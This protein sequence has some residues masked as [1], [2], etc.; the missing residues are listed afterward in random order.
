MGRLNPFLEV[1]QNRPVPPDRRAPARAIL[2]EFCTAVETF[3][4]GGL[5][6]AVTE[7]YQTNMGL[8]HRLVVRSTRTQREHVLL[9]AYIPESG[10]P[11]RLMFYLG[12]PVVTRGEQQ[13]TEALRQYLT[14]EAALD[15]IE[16]YSR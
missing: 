15:A 14:T 2:R 5:T 12:E 11:I 10:T 1:L 13:L 4:H 7:G 16:S 3:K 6:C 9:R 8:E